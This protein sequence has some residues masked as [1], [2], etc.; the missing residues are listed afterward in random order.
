MQTLNTNSHSCPPHRWNPRTWSVAKK[1]TALTVIGVVGAGTFAAFRPDRLFVNQTVN[2]SFPAQTVGAAAPALLSQGT[3]SSLAHRTQGAASIY[4]QGQNHV[5]R[6]MNFSTSNGPDVHVYLTQGEGT[7][8][9]SIKAGHFLDLGVIKGNIGDQNYQLPADF[10]ASKYRGVSIWCK[11]FGVNFAGADLS[12]Q[13]NIV[14]PKTIAMPVSMPV[15]NAVKPVVVTTG[16]FHQIAHATKGVATVFED[17]S[18]NRTLKLANFETGQGPALHLY[19]WK[20]ENVRD[21]ATAKKLVA[22]KHYIDLGA[23]KSVSGAQTYSVPK[24]I[25]LWQYLAVGVWCDKFD[26][27]FG[28]APLASPQ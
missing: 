26:V 5:L 14:A 11:R 8:N 3:F 12:A 9:A 25:D 6:L 21:N 7:D 1:L 20:A 2:E 18:G 16:S 10:D 4:Q 22:S 27:N 24:G 23:L 19:L 15:R 13:R 17:S 28:T